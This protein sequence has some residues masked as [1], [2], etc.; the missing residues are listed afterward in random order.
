MDETVAARYQ[1]AVTTPYTNRGRFK[2]MVLHLIELFIK[3]TF[4]LITES[5]NIVLAQIVKHYPAVDP[6][7][8]FFG[9]VP[10]DFMLGRCK[11]DEYILNG[12]F[13]N[14][15]GGNGDKANVP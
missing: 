12:Q 1:V 8:E 5:R 15:C 11:I 2:P 7:K 14:C 10:E 4:V 3:S 13:I 9:E 6:T